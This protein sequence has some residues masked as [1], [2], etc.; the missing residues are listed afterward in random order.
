[1][2]HDYLVHSLR[3][4]L[5]RKQKEARRGRAELRLAERAALWSEKR[6]N[7]HLPSWWEYLTVVALVPAKNRTKAQH[8]MLAKARRVHVARWCGALALLLA[9]GFAIAHMVSTERREKLHGQTVTAVDAVQNNRGSAVPFT[10]RDLEKL[11]REMVVKEL[12]SR[13]AA[14]EL[15]RKLG[16]AY[17]LAEYGAGDADFLCSQIKLSAPEEVDN[18]A[19]AFGHAREVSLR[20]IQA[21]AAQSQSGQDWRLKA[22]LAVVALQL[23]DDQIVADMCRIDDRP[24]P[25]QRTIFVDEFPAWHGDLEKLVAHCEKLSDPALRSAVCLGIGSIP[26]DRVLPA[27][28][29]AWKPVVSEWHQTAADN[30][31]HSA[32][33]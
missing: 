8:Q 27:D 7:R 10:I 30:V 13:S 15:H 11:P 21:L 2:T 4:W 31:T 9:V 16:L 3:D 6:E 24:D 33:G 32:A 12:K 22:R 19:T 17:A 1:M 18:F 5:T 14:A 20:A 25:V 29:A 26:G 23:G 28:T